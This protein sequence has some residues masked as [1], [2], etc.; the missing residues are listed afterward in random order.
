MFNTLQDIVPA[1]VNTLWSVKRI[2]LL[3]FLGL[4]KGFLIMVTE[5][6]KLRAREQRSEAV[7]F[8]NDILACSQLQNYIGPTVCTR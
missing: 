2:K 8:Y 6:G 5:T 1:D 3:H 7:M 4:S